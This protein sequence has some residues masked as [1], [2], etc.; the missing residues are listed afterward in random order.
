MTRRVVKDTLLP[1]MLLLLTLL[2]VALSLA[3]GWPGA[4]SRRG[5]DQLLEVGGG[6]DLDPGGVGVHL[7]R[8]AAV[9]V[10]AVLVDALVVLGLPHLLGQGAPPLGQLEVNIDVGFGEVL[11]ALEVPPSEEA[12]RE[13][14]PCAARP[15]VDDSENEA[16]VKPLLL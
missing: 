12:G 10:G 11:A 2:L 3:P 9:L 15:S 6:G 14:F 1:T 13:D 5:G 16:G 4:G 8:D 7:D